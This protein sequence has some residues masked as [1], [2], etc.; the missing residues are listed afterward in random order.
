MRGSEKKYESKEN[1]CLF[2]EE[3]IWIRKRQKH[4]RMSS[5]RD[6]FTTQHSHSSSSCSR[7]GSV[8]RFRNELR[9]KKDRSL[10]DQL[11]LTSV[12]I[13]FLILCCN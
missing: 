5:F 7:E 4:H 9:N 10:G 3:R 2:A 6:R 12:D 1:C 11:S 13:D 8:N